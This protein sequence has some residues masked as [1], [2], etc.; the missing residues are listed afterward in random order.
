MVGGRRWLTALAVLVEI[1]DDRAL[2]EQLRGTVSALR[3]VD[4]GAA[5]LTAL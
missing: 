2:L 1:V 5:D 3:P 4:A